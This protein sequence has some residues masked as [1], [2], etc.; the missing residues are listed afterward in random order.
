MMIHHRDAG[1]SHPYY[2]LSELKNCSSTLVPEMTAQHKAMF[3]GL[4]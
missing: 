2:G 4:K 3:T 1:N